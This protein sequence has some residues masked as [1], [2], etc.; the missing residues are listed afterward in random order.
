MKF[1]ARWIHHQQHLR[2][3]FGRV[4][5]YC[6]DEVTRLDCHSRQFHPLTLLAK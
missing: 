2:L 4:K 6:S 3:Q 1:P 5:N